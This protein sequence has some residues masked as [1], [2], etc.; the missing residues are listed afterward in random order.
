MER[1]GKLRGVGKFHAIKERAKRGKQTRRD[2]AVLLSE[3]RRLE[4]FEVACEAA[5]FKIGSVRLRKIDMGK[6]R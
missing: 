3:I 2:V 1:S 6:R 4:P 5:G